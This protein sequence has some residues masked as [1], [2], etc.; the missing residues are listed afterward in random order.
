MSELIQPDRR[1]DKRSSGC[2]PPL[3][4]DISLACFCS[5][6]LRD[7]HVSQPAYNFLD[8]TGW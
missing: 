4:A 7:M 6:G 5:L 1:G 3:W 8:H 2:E